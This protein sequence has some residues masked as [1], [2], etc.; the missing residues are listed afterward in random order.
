[1][2]ILVI[3]DDV[4]MLRTIL[5]YLDSFGFVCEGARSFADGAEKIGTYQYDCIVLDVN[6]TD[7]NGLDLIPAVKESQE[8][9]GLLI[10]S[11][12]DKV[13]DRI[14]GLDE[15]ADDYLTKPFHLAELNARIRSIVRRKKFNGSNILEV[16]SLKIDTGAQEVTVN[17]EK[18]KLTRKEYQLLLFLV[19]NKN[20]V[21]TKMS[22]SEHIW[23]DYIDQAD[24]FDFI[25]AHLKNLRKKILEKGGEDYIQTVY[26]IGY[27]FTVNEPDK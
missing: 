10:L 11:A 2:K 7:G 16:G 17:N 15:G 8:H 21:V 9:T 27:K 4:E 5:R 14:R 20:K 6:L 13:E 25:Y 3:E 23:G 18:L 24:S 22:I 12:N 19:S 1:M 26:G